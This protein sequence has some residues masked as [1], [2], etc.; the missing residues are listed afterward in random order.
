MIVET[1][2]FLESLK[3]FT[4]FLKNFQHAG[5]F[6]SLALVLV[7]VIPADEKFLAKE[8]FSHVIFNSDFFG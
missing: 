6:H 4:F 5:L 3:N 1:C 8:I 2:T 7:A